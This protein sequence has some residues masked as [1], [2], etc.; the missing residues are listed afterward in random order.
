[1][2]LVVCWKFRV[3]V[4]LFIGRV[5]VLNILESVLLV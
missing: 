1:M 4:N 5:L 2:F 3:W